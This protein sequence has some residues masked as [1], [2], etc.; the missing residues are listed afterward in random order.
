MQTRS[1]IRTFLAASGIALAV[2]VLIPSCS[3]EAPQQQTVRI[4]LFGD[5]LAVQ[6]EPYFNLLVEAGGKAKVTDFSYGGTAACDWVSKMEKYA[7]TEHPQ[8]AVFEFIGNT[9]T[10][11]MKGCR[12]RIAGRHHALL[13]GHFDS[14]QRLPRPGDARLSGWH[15]D[16]PVRVDLP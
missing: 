15:S 14:D 5:S 13:L 7:R 8:A 4:G 10:A 2:L 9:F 6:S 1:Q 12:L 3:R 11:C 16:H